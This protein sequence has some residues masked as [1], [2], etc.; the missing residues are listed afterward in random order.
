MEGGSVSCPLLMS[1]YIQLTKGLS[2]LVDDADYEKYN[3]FNW[4]PH[5]NGQK[6]YP[7]RKVKIDGKSREIYLHREI[8]DAPKGVHV[9]HI[10]GNSLDCRRENMRFA[11]PSQN[12][13][14]RRMRSDN[15]TGVVGVSQTRSGKYLAC[16]SIKGRLKRLGLFSTLEEAKAAREAA[17]AKYYGE[18]ARSKDLLVEQLPE[19]RPENKPYQLY[20]KRVNNSSGKTGVSYFRPMKAWRARIRLQSKEKTLGY[21]KTFEEACAAREKAERQYFPQYFKQT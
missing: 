3:Q 14:N 17:E 2:V 7:V 5:Y 6:Y 12:A 8:M 13:M 10:N 11:T 9:D 1:K 4:T 18:Y 20:R 19:P 21:Y 16:Y 15:K